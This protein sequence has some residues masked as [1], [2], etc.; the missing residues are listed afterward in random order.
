MPIELIEVDKN[1]FGDE[2]KDEEK[3]QYVLKPVDYDPFSEEYQKRPGYTDTSEHEFKKLQARKEVPQPKLTFGR[4][5][6]AFV[7][8]AKDVARQVPL[9]LGLLMQ[10]QSD[11]DKELAKEVREKALKMGMVR[12]DYYKDKGETIYPGE[13]KTAESLKEVAKAPWMQSS[14]EYFN[15]SGLIED[16]IRVGPQV[17]TQ[18][19]VSAATGGIGSTI[20]MGAQILASTYEQEK[21]KGVDDDRAINAGIA[22]AIMQAP[23]EQL[24]ISKVTKFWSVR[25]SILNKLKAYG[26]T[27]GTE[28]LTEFLQQF[29]DAAVQIWA[30]N[31]DEALLQKVDKFVQQ[32]PDT[33]LEGAKQG[34]SVVPWAFIGGGLGNV[35]KQQMWEKSLKK[36]GFSD[37]DI[38][39]LKRNP[40]LDPEDFLA[41]KSLYEQNQ[42][43]LSNQMSDVAE[44]DKAKVIPRANENS[45]E[46]AASKDLFAALRS[47][48]P[49]SQHPTPKTP[50]E[51][52]KYGA[53]E[54]AVEETQDEEKKI[55][56]VRLA[57]FQ[58]Q[59]QI[60]AEWENQKAEE[61]ARTEAKII[62]DQKIDAKADDVIARY[63]HQRLMDD[64]STPNGLMDRTSDFLRQAEA[65]EDERFKDLSKPLRKLHR[66][67]AV[68]AKNPDKLKGLAY[69]L[70]EATKDITD[71]TIGAIVQGMTNFATAQAEG[72]E[73]NEAAEKLNQEQIRQ[74]KEKGREVQKKKSDEGAA[75]A[76]VAEKEKAKPTSVNRDYIPSLAKAEAERN[77]KR[78]GEE[79]R[80]TSRRGM[81]KKYKN[82]TEEEQ[83][84]AQ[85]TAR[86]AGT[87]GKEEGA[88]GGSQE[89]LR[90][91]YSRQGGEG[92]EGQKERVDKAALRTPDGKIYTG[93]SHG[94]AYIDNPGLNKFELS[95]LEQG[96]TTNSGRFVSRSE[97]AE[98]SGMG[99]TARGFN[100]HA[101]SED[102]EHLNKAIKEKQRGLSERGFVSY[103]RT[104]DNLARAYGYKKDSAKAKEAWAGMVKDKLEEAVGR[105]GN[106]A[107]IDVVASESDLPEAAQEQ[108]REDK[109]E[110]SGAYFHNGKVTVIAGNNQ[111]ILEAKRNAWHELG[112]YSFD[113]LLGD[114]ARSL[115]NRVALKYRPEIN[116]RL[117]GYGLEATP[118]LIQNE[119]EEVLIDK[120]LHG[121]DAT[122]KDHVRSAFR[123]LATKIGFSEK[124]ITDSEIRSLVARMRDN[125]IYNKRRS[126]SVS[127][128]DRPQMQYARAKEGQKGTSLGFVLKDDILEITRKAGGAAK[129]QDY[130]NRAGV[131]KG[132][133]LTPEGIN[134]ASNLVK[135]LDKNP[136]RLKETE[137]ITATRRKISAGTLDENSSEYKEVLKKYGP[138]IE[139]HTIKHRRRFPV[140][141]TLV[142]GPANPKDKKETVVK[143][144]AMQGSFTMDTYA[145]K[146]GNL[147]MNTPILSTDP[148]KRVDEI[149]M[150][151]KKNR[152]FAD[153]YQSWNDFMHT[154]AGKD[155]TPEQITKFIKVQAV[156][157]AQSGPQGNQKQF[158]AVANALMKDGRV[159]GGPKG[160]G[161]PGVSKFDAVKINKIWEGTDAG[162]D[163]DSRKIEY[164][165]KVGAFM[166]AGL[167][168]SNPD[169]I[170]IDRH[171]PRLWGYNVSWSPTGMHDRFVVAPQVE[172]EIV[173][174]IQAAAKRLN[175]TSAGVQSALWFES[176]L[177]DVEASSYQEAIRIKPSEYLPYVMYDKTIP[178]SVG[179]GVH[180]Q[181][182]V[183]K[184][185][186]FFLAAT[187]DGKI[188]HSPY[189]RNDTLK[190]IEAHTEENPYAELVYFYESGT[191]PES[192]V[193]QHQQRYTIDLDRRRIYNGIEDPLEYWKTVNQRL[194]K[195]P[196]A[197]KV[198][199]LSNLLSQ[200][201]DYDGF[202]IE[203]PY[204]DGR[205]VMMFSPVAVQDTPVAANLGLSDVIESVEQL[206]QSVAELK[207]I[208]GKRAADF[209]KR[210]KETHKRYPEVQLERVD[211]A[212]AKF[213]DATADKME[214]SSAVKVRGP[215]PAIRSMAAELGIEHSQRN[216]YVMSTEGKPNGMFFRFKVDSKL[217]TPEKV[218]AE[219]EK[220]G[221]KEWNLVVKPETGSI[222]VEQFV[223][224]DSE[225]TNSDSVKDMIKI[226]E[227]LEH[228][229]FPANE[230]FPIHSQVLGTFNENADEAL[231]SYREQIVKYFG[232]ENGERVYQEALKRRE[233]YK[234]TL[235]SRAVPAADEGQKADVEAGAT[236]EGLGK[237]R[238]E[239]LIRRAGQPGSTSAKNNAPLHY[240]RPKKEVRQHL[241]RLLKG[242]TKYPE[243]LS[244][245][246]PL[247]TKIKVKEYSPEVHNAAAAYFRF[248]NTITIFSENQPD[249]Y[250]LKKYYQDR[251]YKDALDEL[252]AHE[253]I[254]AIFFERVLKDQVLWPKVYK[255]LAAFYNSITPIARSQYD[256]GELAP[257]IAE[258]LNQPF[259]NKQLVE[260]LVTYGFTNPQFAQWLANIPVK[261]NVAPHKSTTLW[262]KFKDIILKYIQPYVGKTKLD[263]LHE[264]MDR[265]LILAPPQD[266]KQQPLP[267]KPKKFQ[268][269][270]GDMRYARKAN[271]KWL[272]KKEWERIGKLEK[273]GLTEEQIKQQLE[274]IEEHY[275]QIEGAEPELDTEWGEYTDPVKIIEYNYSRKKVL[276]QVDPQYHDTIK[277]IG[278]YNDP[279]QQRVGQLDATLWDKIKMNLFDPLDRLKKLE[280][281]QGGVG[282]S[283]S[284]YVSFNMTTNFPSIL[285]SMLND[286][287]L[288]WKNN[289][290]SLDMN[291]KNQDGSWKGGL[292][293]VIQSLGDDADLFLLRQTA[294]SAGE[295]L[296]KDAR[297]VARG[298]PSRFKPG[299][300]LFGLDANGNQIN[301]VQQVTE[302]L[303]ATQEAYDR[304][305]ALWDAGEARLR[306]INKSI[307]DIGESAGVLNPS[308]RAS[309]ERHHYVPFF[310]VVSD[311]NDGEVENLFPKSGIKIGK[312][313]MLKGSSKRMGDPLANLVNSYSYLLHQSLRNI[314][315]VKAMNSLNSFGLIDRTGPQDRGKNVVDIRIDGKSQFFKVLDRYAFDAIMDIDQITGGK[316]SNFFRLPK[317]WLTWGVTMNP[318]F[319][320]ANFIRDSIHTSFMDKDFKPWHSLAGAYHAWFNTD[321][322]REYRATGGSFSGAYHQRDVIQGTEKSI[323]K[324]KKRLHHKTQNWHP[325]KLS[326]LWER[327]GE[328]SENAARVGLYIQK[329]KQGKSEIEA[330]YTSKDLLDFHRSGKSTLLRHL[331]SSIPFLNARLQGLYRVGRAGWG[332]GVKSFLFR[333]AL[334]A[335]IAG[336]LH[337]WNDDD[338]R[339]KELPNDER[340]SYFH[341]WDV[342]GLGHVRIP[343]PFE[344]GIIFGTAPVVFGQYLANEIGNKELWDYIKFSVNDTLRMDVPQWVKPWMQQYANR[345]YYTGAPIVPRSQERVEPELQYG[346]R[347]TE[348]TK[349]VSKAIRNVPLPD[350]FKSPRRMEKL[351]QDYFSWVGYTSMAMANI[352][353]RFIKDYP[354]DP[355]MQDTVEYMLG[356]NRFVRG[357]GPQKRTKQEN[358]FYE[359]LNDAEKAY[360]S[361]NTWKRLR[362]R[363]AAKQ[364]KSERIDILKKYKK[365]NRVQ[366][367]LAKMR[368]QENMIDS[369]PKMDVDQ[370]RQA[371]DKLSIERNEMLQK[372]MDKME[373]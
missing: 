260:E 188:E 218:Q 70:H 40:L 353:L 266:E 160:D 192:F 211:P 339:Y 316:F 164:G 54:T 227:A 268:N 194:K 365:L 109:A 111:S 289:W 359:M 259:K 156:L 86:Q 286:G 272:A 122:L 28:W 348:V 150:I 210:I 53:S 340:Y 84:Y 287:K 105:I 186:E 347:T 135:N 367:R 294:K 151:V 253:A 248:D 232:E 354:S 315:R 136:G 298:E 92:Q 284:S 216:A 224:D 114:K 66:E 143:K 6:G 67:L 198:N 291:D 23:L 108:I 319:R 302:L 139:G 250:E 214:V 95:D 103:S 189:S 199:I 371:L 230:H 220:L 43:Q 51:I 72:L 33:M 355:A 121:K 41:H 38:Q 223:F 244:K 279:V 171:M 154:F 280:K 243:L 233:A 296:A 330:G 157:S 293:S 236:P 175:M 307:L 180:Y 305:P 221:S 331:A 81:L 166:S 351:V 190:R 22:N 262:Q 91:R 68:G 60:A 168:P 131:W 231:P 184:K 257:Y 183:L 13:E 299:R 148:K 49:S 247:G 333:G 167:E 50:G 115:R 203:S 205:W 102:F 158:A 242:G 318:A 311:W 126:E 197:D 240:A 352:G 174:D 88:Q 234:A 334:L 62:E 327:V 323:E 369:D 193:K 282:T 9:G 191:P 309:W 59:K 169:A 303:R 251:P 137:E 80:A 177:P 195:D 31:P 32:L 312:I 345:D 74:D 11:A 209:S 159:E 246:K 87:R 55:N 320:V 125:L 101:D 8:G 338:P 107:K 161:K 44:D 185:G 350:E 113:D 12:P 110:G 276:D 138:L 90:L 300:N 163:V 56:R 215:L 228:K 162:T 24:G 372:T 3:D 357:E 34:I 118:D 324:L 99:R 7:E 119:A 35:A 106:A 77:A 358:D 204:H 281:I 124:E 128:K 261:D 19:P 196:Q 278:F 241:E 219:I 97:A 82:K 344:V 98:L 144:H 342:P 301:D 172:E 270:P 349:E 145:D 238:T 187:R 15:S 366:S 133:A 85:S 142:Y 306:E 25:G 76:T 273:A 27:L 346:P 129:V 57:Q 71:P 155:L 78:K 237:D 20:M 263:E 271:K 130:L 321:W 42:D 332:K 252:L 94:F 235:L 2:E 179:M 308:T 127:H 4:A 5:A 200:T 47:E 254:H 170:A 226:R 213:P 153:W 341:M 178:S 368:V 325:A 1:P 361:L 229:G 73:Y 79:E 225:L 123:G 120:F 290:V 277:R 149:D 370:K 64:I 48:D 314:S 152:E 297:R 275:T 245:L 335:S 112:H 10:R 326:Q 313:H 182:T 58:R 206:P 75:S 165:R 202:L 336:L 45:D 329:R 363:D 93:V 61:Q 104:K 30:E 134:Y 26:E 258:I 29:P 255:D 362:D 176:R 69:D 269:K 274:D 222:F 63:E 360:Y 36:Q 181:D 265:W 285:S 264:I 288:L 201:G 141:K 212:V 304:N 310:R 343:I 18:I 140:G 116:R 217:D 173:A 37:V 328:A 207:K 52:G 283:E 208:M 292:Y 295:I 373:D 16:I 147:V 89:R 117:S 364:Y 249:S 96:F 83:R 337:I 256:R 46:K 317:K 39:E 146:A 17:L 132:R 322:M 100:Y 267:F 356:I 65:S 21:S 14:P 239:G